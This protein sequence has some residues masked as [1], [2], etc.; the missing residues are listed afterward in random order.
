[1][2]VC[3]KFGDLM[4][5]SGRVIQLVAGRTRF[6]HFCLV[7]NCIF[8]ADRKQ[9]VTSGVNFRHVGIDVTVTFDGSR[10]S[11]SPAIRATQFVTNERTNEHDRGLRHLGGIAL[12]FRL[13]TTDVKVRRNS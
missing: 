13:K 1:M 4:L 8:A 9:Q 10:S 12:V 7:F 2:D 6:T 3:V 11:R 5:N